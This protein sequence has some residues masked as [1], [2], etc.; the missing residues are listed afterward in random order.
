MK[1]YK[2]NIL[3]ATCPETKWKKIRKLAHATFS[4]HTLFVSSRRTNPALCMN[5]CTYIRLSHRLSTTL[6]LCL[7]IV[8]LSAVDFS[9][10]KT[11]FS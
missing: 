1:A 2:R 4:A 9:Q 8:L 11:I 6:F 5:F 7:H 10:R 3:T